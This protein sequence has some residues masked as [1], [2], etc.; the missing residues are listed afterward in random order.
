MTY[1][2]M[3]N[4]IFDGRYLVHF[5]HSLFIDAVIATAA[6]VLWLWLLA[7]VPGLSL[8]QMVLV[9]Y[10]MVFSLFIFNFRHF[11]R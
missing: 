3:E 7:A 8:A 1:L 6:M 9:R 4:S 10:S 11:F 5:G 2:H